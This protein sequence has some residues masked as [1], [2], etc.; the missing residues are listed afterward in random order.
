MERLVA[1]SS[2]LEQ[3]GRSFLTRFHQQA[4]NQLG[5][6]S[7]EEEGLPIDAIVRSK[8][9]AGL[10]NERRLFNR[11]VSAGSRR[12]DSVCNGPSSTDSEIGASSLL[13]LS[14]L[15]HPLVVVRSP[16]DW[17]VPGSNGGH[18]S[19]HQVPVYYPG[20]PVKM[21]VFARSSLNY[22]NIE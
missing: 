7:P 16:P 12:N 4:E 22:Y 18:E 2:D 5:G 8:A 17:R 11:C 3:M 13:P 9:D 19:L 21:I 15:S 14:L 20:G 10:S 1:A 6:E